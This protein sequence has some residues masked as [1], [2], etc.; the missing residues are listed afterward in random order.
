M[1]PLKKLTVIKFN[2]TDASII[3]ESTRLRGNNSH[4]VM[5]VIK[6]YKLNTCVSSENYDHLWLSVDIVPH[7]IPS[8]NPFHGN[9][10]NNFSGPKSL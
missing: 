4:I 2:S 5:S 1:S 7:D 3:A 6:C 10:Y 9:C 8:W